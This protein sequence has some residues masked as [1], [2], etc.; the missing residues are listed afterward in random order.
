MGAAQILAIGTLLVLVPHL[1]RN[2]ATRWRLFHIPHDT[3]FGRVDFGNPLEPALTDEV[4]RLLANVP[5][6][7]IYAYPNFISIYLTAGANNPTPYQFF[8]ASHSPP[9]HTSAV[10]S[11]LQE[12]SLPYIVGVT[13]LMTP[14]DP[15]VRYIFDNYDLVDIPGLDNSKIP[16]LLLYRR[17]DLGGA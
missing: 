1:V 7:E 15:V 5:G 16:L 13:I 6:R 10:L 3:A 8:K 14:S 11:I 17:K 12:R 4:R 2:F 9:E